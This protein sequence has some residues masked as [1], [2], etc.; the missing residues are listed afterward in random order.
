MSEPHENAHLD[1]MPP[2]KPTSP[3]AAKVTVSFYDDGQVLVDCVNGH[4]IP[5]GRFEKILH[6]V[7]WALGKAR[8]DYL[9]KSLK[10][11]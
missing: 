10:G 4:T 5:D 6:R 1:L 2:P 3:P 7:Y 9:Q 11:K 8:M